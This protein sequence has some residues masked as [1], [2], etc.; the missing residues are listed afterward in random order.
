MLKYK[1]N[2]NGFDEIIKQAEYKFSD[3]SPA[4]ETMTMRVFEESVPYMPF[5]TAEFVEQSRLATL[6]TAKHGVITYTRP[7]SGYDPAVRLWVGYTEGGK[8][9]NYTKTFNDRAGGLW[10][11][12]M[13]NDKYSVLINEFQE[14]L[15]R[16]EL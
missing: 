13:L 7:S 6:R 16:G 1:V 2:Y 5:V 8:A 12:R 4:L 15:N 10:T 9:F 3:G 11:L 14:L